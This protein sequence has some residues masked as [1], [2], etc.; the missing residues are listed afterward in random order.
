M[1][2]ELE[3]D[4]SDFLQ[5]PEVPIFTNFAVFLP[6]YAKQFNAIFVGIN[7][8][9]YRTELCGFIFSLDSTFGRIGLGVEGNNI[10]P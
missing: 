5:F 10:S 4:C 2:P 8:S 7:P 3:A 9:G 6:A 1:N